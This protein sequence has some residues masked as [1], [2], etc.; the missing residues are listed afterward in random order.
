MRSRRL[1]G[2][3]FILAAAALLAGTPGKA[4]GIIV[5]PADEKARQRLMPV[6][7]DPV[8]ALLRK[9]PVQADVARGA[10]SAQP[11]PEV[12][13][14]GGHEMSVTGFMVP[15]D[16]F[17]I[18]NHFLLSRNTP[19]CPFCPPGEPNEVIEVY[20]SAFIK[21]TTS[22]ITVRGRFKVQDNAAAGLFFEIEG[23]A[24]S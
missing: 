20:T 24:V 1:V 19:V 15:L 5:Q 3:S 22:P 6:S 7:S 9:T 12:Q 21:P 18:I 14:L 4:A 2:L 8:W 13:A 23:G 16:P 17:P 11:P 10:F